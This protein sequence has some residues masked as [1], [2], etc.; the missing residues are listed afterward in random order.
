MRK[1]QKFIASCPYNQQSSIQKGSGERQ[2]ERGIRKEER[3]VRVQKAEVIS[4]RESGAALCDLATRV[5]KT[6]TL[7]DIR[8]CGIMVC[9]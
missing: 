7:L 6:M 5:T 9:I 4:S 1:K 2:E 8:G 3:E